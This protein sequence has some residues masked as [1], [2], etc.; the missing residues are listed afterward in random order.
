MTT[1]PTSD[2]GDVTVLLDRARGG[3]DEALERA[4]ALVYDELRRIAG[5]QLGR[6]KAGHTL[7]P[8]AL[9]NEAYLK[10]VQSPPGGAS[11][12]AHFVALASRA[13]RQVLVDHARARTA[14]KRGGGVVP[15]T[16]DR[17][18]PGETADP[19]EILAL[20]A[21][22]DRLDEVDSR[23]RQVVEMRYFGGMTE[24]EIAEVLD[25]ARRTVSR[26]WA[27]ARAWLHREL[28]GGGEAEGA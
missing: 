7:Q 21:A 17:E 16:L 23:L 26:D 28:T 15:V 19:T 5:A 24:E 9:V 20:D 3:E 2:P 13:M 27:K 22:L 10:L 25:V 18:M 4:F 8:T 1:D 14:Q 6:E 11:D 12:R